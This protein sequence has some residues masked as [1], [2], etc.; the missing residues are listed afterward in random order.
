M[1][2]HWTTR[3]L[4]PVVGVSAKTVHRGWHTHGLQ[5]HLIRTFKLSRDSQFVEQ[6]TDVVGLYPN[7]PD[8]TLVFCADKKSQIQALDRTQPRLP[9]RT[10]RCDT[11][12]HD[13][14]RQ[15]TAT[16]FAALN[17]LTG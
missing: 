7:P 9:V 13:Y 17:V 4:A 8:I 12:T 6:L 1:A 5:P 2:T 3:T 11:L 10:G 15:G 16:L 14:K